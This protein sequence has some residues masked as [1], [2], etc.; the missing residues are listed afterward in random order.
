MQNPMDVIDRDTIIV[1][2][3]FANTNS[4]TTT[5]NPVVA[6]VHAVIV[7]GIYYWHDGNFADGPCFLHCDLPKNGSGLLVAFDEMNFPIVLDTHVKVNEFGPGRQV[8][9][10]VLDI[11]GAPVNIEGNLVLTLE[12]QQYNI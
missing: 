11:A 1:K 7:K 3:A 5:L 2:N 12:C 10:N 6:R 8:T 4:F 9:F